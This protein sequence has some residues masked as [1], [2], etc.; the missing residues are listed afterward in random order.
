MFY[1]SGNGLTPNDQLMLTA[2]SCDNATEQNLGLPG[3]PSLMLP[4]PIYE[5]PGGLKANLGHLPVSASPGV[6]QICWCPSSSECSNFKDFRASAGWLQIDCPAGSFF[7]ASQCKL[8]GRAFYCPGGSIVAAARFPCPREGQTTLVLDAAGSSDCVCAEG[9]GNA[10]GRCA[11]CARGFYKPTEG[12]SP[13]N[14]CPPNLTTYSEGSISLKNCISGVESDEVFVS[15][16][17]PVVRFEISLELHHW[18]VAPSFSE[19]YDTLLSAA[20]ASVGRS[21][22]SVSVYPTLNDEPERRPAE[23]QSILI[24]NAVIHLKFLSEARATLTAQEIDSSIVLG[25][26][27]SG[28]NLLSVDVGNGSI[29]DPVAVLIRSEC[30]A[31]AAVARGMTVLSYRDCLCIPG[32]EFNR[33]AETCDPCPQGSFQPSLSR[34]MCIRCGP[35]RWTADEGANSSEQCYCAPGTYD[36]ERVGFCA[37]CQRGYYCD[38][39]GY[40]ALCPPHSTTISEGASSETSCVCDEGYEPLE[41]AMRLTCK[42]CR[43]SFEKLILGN[44]ACTSKC[45]ANTESRGRDQTRDC[46]CKP[47]YH[48]ILRDDGGL[49]LCAECSSYWGLT[50]PGAYEPD[51]TTHA[52]PRAREGFFK[53]GATSAVQCMVLRSNGTSACLGSSGY[54]SN[55]CAEGATGRLCGECP[56]QWARGRHLK[57]CELCTSQ[58]SFGLVAAILAD[59]VRITVLNFGMAVLSARTAATVSLQLHSPMLRMLLRWKDACSVLVGFDL[60]RLLPFSWAL[61]AA[62]ATGQCSGAEC[63]LLRFQ[64]PRE[65]TEAMEALFSIMAILPKVNVEFAMACEAE[66]WF[67]DNVAAKRLAPGL[68][69]LSLPLLALIGTLFVCAVAAYALIPLCNRLGFSLSDADRMESSRR[70]V[71]DT[72]IRE[73]NAEPPESEVLQRFK[74][75][76]GGCLAT[77][78]YSA[79]SSRFQ[80]SK[81]SRPNLHLHAFLPLRT[82]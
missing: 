25:D 71:R 32:Y 27:S 17:V 7:H 76:A 38:G 14:P 31:N 15:F 80:A 29:S 28:L 54:H 33:V 56:A 10:G 44:V 68:Y 81:S 21:P 45:P 9:Y 4:L 78:C 70:Q 23:M 73:L 82:S 30:R 66:A 58:G 8:C 39:S 6:Y 24:L 43:P 40:Q 3:F 12:L 63:A 11:P 72:V 59:L 52:Q 22:L 61:R 67:P 62:D 41:A 48:A 2:S 1:V 37:P 46:F 77:L 55:K 26:V 36:E 18:D 42:P 69:Y 65:V 57:P 75:I 53:T 50:C 49:S 79:S 51:G 60:E 20:T 35:G 19:L 34:L 13:C 16:Q 64:W 74:N 47:G 5:D